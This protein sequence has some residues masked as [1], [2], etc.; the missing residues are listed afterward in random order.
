MSNKITNASISLTETRWEEIDK[1]RYDNRI[2][3]RS[4]AVELLLKVALREGTPQ[5]KIR[6]CCKGMKD[7]CSEDLKPARK[8]EYV[9]LLN[10]IE[11]EVRKTR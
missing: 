6:S 8:K 2:K 1:Y 3:T 11:R 5:E 4:A 7:L 10:R 9:A